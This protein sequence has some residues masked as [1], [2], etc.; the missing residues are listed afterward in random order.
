MTNSFL[1]L[2]F[3]TVVTTFVTSCGSSSSSTTV[4]VG[5][6]GGSIRVV[7]LISGSSA[8]VTAR[9]RRQVAQSEVPSDYSGTV[10]TID[11]LT[12]IYDSEP[13]SLGGPVNFL[14]A[15]D[16]T[17]LAAS[18]YQVSDTTLSGEFLAEVQRGAV[19]NTVF[20]RGVYELLDQ[21]SYSLILL[22][23]SCLTFDRVTFSCVAGDVTALQQVLT[24][25]PDPSRASLRVS[26][27]GR[28]GVDDEFGG[29][30]MPEVFLAGPGEEV[31]GG[32]SLDLLPRNSYELSSTYIDLEQGFY[33]LQISLEIDGE[34]QTVEQVLQL[35]SSQSQEVYLTLTEDDS[36]VAT[37]R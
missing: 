15:G 13:L 32:V 1:R 25:N 3:L 18:Q 6:E 12:F 17:S 7:N 30:L 27:F 5:G 28:H 36:L 11:G 31:D 23:D 14:S 21:F 2:L 24:E 20:L 22:T 19:R 37:V 8:S 9:S 10:S 4:T 34:T 35:D 16:Y 26:F 33:R 29:D